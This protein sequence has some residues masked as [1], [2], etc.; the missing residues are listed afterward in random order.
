VDDDLIIVAGDN[1]FSESVDGFGR[2]AVRRT[3]RCSRSMTFGNTGEIKK[4]NAITFEQGRSDYFLRGEAEESA[5]YRHWHRA[6]NYYP[7]FTAA[8]H[9][10]NTS[11]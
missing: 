5:E 1:L 4:Y 7:K 9:Q 6:F 8:A 11:P 2:S 3:R 10:N